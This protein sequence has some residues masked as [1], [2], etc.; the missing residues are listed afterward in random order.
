MARLKKGNR[1]K[2]KE[3]SYLRFRR[4]RVER[5]ISERV[6]FGDIDS[7]AEVDMDVELDLH[8]MSRGGRGRS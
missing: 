8:G 7:S 6:V 4:G 3:R 5:V 2:K 1:R